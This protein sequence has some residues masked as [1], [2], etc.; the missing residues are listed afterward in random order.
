MKKFCLNC[1]K[2]LTKEQH[3][4][5]FCCSACSSQYRSKQKLEAWKNGEFDGLSGKNS[6]SKTIRNYMLEKVN[7]QCELCGWHEINPFT[8]L[9][10]LEIH[11][12]DGNYLNNTEENLQ[13]LCPNCHSLTGSFRALNRDKGRPDREEARKKVN[14]CVDCGKPISIGATRCRNCA[15]KLLV[16]EKPV[17]REELKKLIRTIPFTKIAEKYGVTD[18]AIVKWCIGYNLPSR[19]KDIN[20]ISDED[21]EK[22]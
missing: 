1:G 3:Y 15:N 22:I 9:V 8:N 2:E 16:T 11:H 6:I 13:V 17:T 10:P 19:K 12:K 18:K 21:W 7:Y 14:L 4:N 5:K 20:I